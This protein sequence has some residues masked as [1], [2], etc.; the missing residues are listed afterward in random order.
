MAKIEKLA[1]HGGDPVK[2]TPFGY[3]EE[4]TYDFEQARK[5]TYGQ[6][7]FVMVDGQVI[8]SYEELVQLAARESYRD[9][10]FLE[11]MILYRGVVEGG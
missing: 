3:T 1:I 10:E 9:H 11:V 7:S 4:E 6:G 8:N 2:K 5:F